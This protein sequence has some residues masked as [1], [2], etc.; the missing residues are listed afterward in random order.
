MRIEVTLEHIRNGRRNSC[1]ACPIALAIVDAANVQNP[2]VG[3]RSVSIGDMVYRLPVAAQD[4][5]AS[6]DTARDVEPFSFDLSDPTKSAH[7]IA[8]GKQGD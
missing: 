3:S 7:A 8:S 2:T 4:F 5:I 1:Y 6:F